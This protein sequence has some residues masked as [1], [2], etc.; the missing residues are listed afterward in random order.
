[1]KTELTIV[2]IGGNVIDD[3]NMLAHV[4]REFSELPGEKILVHGGGKAAST[5][6]S[7]LGITSQYH[8]GRRITSSEEL[9]IVT[10]VYAGWISKNIVAQLSALGLNAIGLCGADCNVIRATK[11][12]ATPIDFG[13]VG[14]VESVNSAFLKILLQQEII[15]V[16]SAITHDGKGTLLNTNAD[17]I[18]GSVAQALAGN[19]NV[20]LIYCFEKR[21][22]LFDEKDENSVLSNISKDEF[23]EWSNKGILHSGILP[24][25][26]NCF[27]A[28]D[29]GVKEVHITN[30]SN[31]NLT[32]AKTS[33][34]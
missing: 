2:K 21:G 33:F 8:Q 13:F 23:V 15:P 5:L 11:R 32:G 18:A 7:Q 31:L 22:V 24:K 29:A 20:K 6:S 19:F 1:M 17:T 26:Q 4:L 12:S 16:L 3:P 27:D 25:I 9:K 14:D 28:V 10:K 30:P 34:V